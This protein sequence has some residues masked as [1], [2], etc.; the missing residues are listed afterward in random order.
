MAMI[1]VCDDLD[2]SDFRS[3]TLEIDS[4]PELKSALK[5]RGWAQASIHRVE[6]YSV[7]PFF[8][9]EV[10]VAKRPIDALTEADF[11]TLAE[12]PTQTA[13]KKTGSFTLAVCAARL[14][15]DREW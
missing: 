10:L 5:H 8:E 14:A 6:W 4:L 12:L 1:R 2:Y 3:E 15:S 13:D 7:E 9:D 11:E